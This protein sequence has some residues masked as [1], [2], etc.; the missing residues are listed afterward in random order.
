VLPN[1][2][3]VGHQK[4][5]KCG[6]CPWWPWQWTKYVFHANLAQIRSAVPEI[7]HT[8]IDGAEN[9]TFCSSVRVV[10]ICWRGLWPIG[11]ESAACNCHIAATTKRISQSFSP[12]VV[13]NCVTFSPTIVVHAVI[14]HTKSLCIHN[15]AFICSVEK[16][17]MYGHITCP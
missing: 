4:G 9:R 14:T 2:P 16:I 7:F 17:I 12:D 8:Q 10:I 3:H 15:L 1:K 13:S 11:S 5:Q 6:F